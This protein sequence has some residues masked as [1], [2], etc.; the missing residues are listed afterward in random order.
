MNLKPGFY[1]F[2]KGLGLLLLLLSFCTESLSQTS[3]RGKV[4]DGESNEGLPFVNILLLGTTRGTTSD[5]DGNYSLSTDQVCDSIAVFYLGY[6][7]SVKKVKRNTSQEINFVLKRKTNI[8]PE[9]VINPGENPALRIFRNVVANKDRNNREKLDAYE[10]EVYNKIE[11]DLKDIPHEMQKWKILR[12]VKFAFDHIDSSNANEKPQL[13]IMISEATSEYYYKSNPVIK[14]EIIT[15]NKLAGMEQKSISQFMGDMYLDVNL[16]Q[17]NIL[18]FGKSFV[19][20]ISDNGLFYYRYYLLDSINL[21]GHKCYQLRFVPR[22]KQEL[23]FTGNMWIADTSWAVK[24]IE[25]KVVD[26]AN[27]NFI[28]RLSVNQEYEFT[29]GHWMLVRDHLFTDMYIPAQKTG[30]YGRKTATYSHIK[31]NKPRDDGFYSRTN[32]LIVSENLNKPDSYWIKARPDSLSKN[33]QSI[34]HLMDTIQKLPVYKTWYDLILMLA[35]GYKPMGNIEIGP[36]YTIFSSNRIEGNR[37]RIGGRTSDKFSKWY[38]LNG[39]SAFG[40]KDEQFKYKLGFRTFITK[41]PR[42]LASISYKSDY[43]LLGQSQNAFQQDN[44][45]ATLLSRTPIRNLTNIEQL[46]AVYE[47]EAFTGFNTKLFLVTRTM[48]PISD[49]LYQYYSKDGTLI[50]KDFIKTTELRFVGRLAWHEKYIDGTFSHIPTGTKY[51]ILQITYT[52]GFRNAF[53]SDYEYNKLAINITDRVRIAPAGY[54]DYMIQA[55]KVY[56][57]VP[58]PLLE[59]HG[60]NETYVYDPYAFNMMNYYEFVSDQYL[61]VQAQYHLDGFFLNHIPLMRKLKWREVATGKF[62]A[63]S[64]SDQNRHLLNFPASLSSLNAGPYYEVGAGIENIF[65]FFRI[66]AL[67]RLSYLDHSNIA[68]FGL[69]GTMQFV[70]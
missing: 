15:A 55:G 67:W 68:K 59:L 29:D 8:I 50:T 69:R 47:L 53:Q 19:S 37:I 10:Y 58:Y 64:V 30:L 42:Q 31:V 7:R 54:I 43:E 32:Y 66:D 65:H 23:L 40:T 38:E 57:A 49:F 56:G 4:I 2:G 5:I 45:F 34:Y 9:I 36:Y 21:S 70:F 63:G 61:T 25:M 27:I 51:P 48:T 33:E 39:Y 3:I 14:K 62:L 13:P 20:P 12:P 26:D 1:V 35:K 52:K 6:N 11:F 46:E 41:S 60:G 22:R 28:N 17:N 16:Y 44:I 24:R 18:V